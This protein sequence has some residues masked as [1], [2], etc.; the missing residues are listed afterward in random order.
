MH[1]ITISEKKEAIN[2]E[3]IEEYMR[4]VLREEKKKCNYIINSKSG[5]LYYNKQMNFRTKQTNIK[6]RLM[7][8]PSG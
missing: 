7:R 4:N 3:N 8:W 1:S 6:V 5:W 2:W